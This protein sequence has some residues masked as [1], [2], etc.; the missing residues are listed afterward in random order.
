MQE[1]SRGVAGGGMQH[2]K[3]GLAVAGFED[4]GWSREPRNADGLEKL[5]KQIIPVSL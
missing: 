5:E 2:G 3:D 4:G 1:G